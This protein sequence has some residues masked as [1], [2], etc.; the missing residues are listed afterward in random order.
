M[1][2]YLIFFLFNAFRKIVYLINRLPSPTYNNK[3][4]R[5]IHFNK[6]PALDHLRVF[7]SQC[8]PFLGNTRTDKHSPKY[9]PCVFLGYVLSYRGYRCLDPST[10]KVYI[11]RHVQFLE[12]AFPFATHSITFPS[13]LSHHHTLSLPF[14]SST[15][16]FVTPLKPG[17]L[18]D[19]R[20][21]AENLCL[22]S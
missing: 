6:P 19:Y 17:C 22:I 1:H 13:S 9:K 14:S 12:D 11:S 10:N 2:I 7:R 8:F 3:P 18:V 20:Q 15:S 5:K 4:P 16:L 21:P